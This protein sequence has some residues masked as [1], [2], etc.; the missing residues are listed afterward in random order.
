MKKLLSLFAL[1]ACLVLANVL[2]ASARPIQFWYPD[3]LWEK[4]DLVVMATAESSQDASSVP[5]TEAKPNTWISVLTKFNV[6]AVLKGDLGKKSV[7]DKMFVTVEHRRYFDKMA[8]V[9]EV[10]GPAFVKFNPEIK[11]QYMIFLKGTN[12]ENYQ[13]LTGQYDPWQSFLR[14]EQYNSSKEKTQP[15]EPKPDEE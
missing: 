10:D 11:N 6:Q 7:T 13:P 3:E 1:T 15:T 12:G 5:P 14:L 4:A 9:T 8:E 2:P